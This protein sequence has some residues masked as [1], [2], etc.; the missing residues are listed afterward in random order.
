[1]DARTCEIRS[2]CAYA[3]T[4]EPASAGPGPS[5]LA[6]P[7]RPFVFRTRGLEGRTFAPGDEVLIG[8]NLFDTRQSTLDYF[9]QAIADMVRE[10]LGPGRGSLQLSDFLMLDAMGA[11]AREPMTLPLTPLIG[12]PGSIEVRF[13]TPTELKTA[14]GLAD[15]P[16]FPALFT[17]ARDRISTLRA[18]YGSG[19]LEIDFK[20]MAERAAAVTLVRSNI[21]TVSVTRHSSR[22][23]QTHPLGGFTGSAEYRGPLAEFLPFLHVARWT[24]IGRQ[25]VWGKGEI[26]VVTP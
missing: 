22:T 19:P 7:P 11:P 12:A 24:G 23:G 13:L 8:V 25:T 3:T 2:T 15:T 20:A 21:A 4:F 17:R 6:D 26:E 16:E 14:S 9:I 5:G 1:M 18:L 10:G